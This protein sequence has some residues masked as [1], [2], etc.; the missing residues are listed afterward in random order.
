MLWSLQR[1]PTQRVA[2]DVP[3][4]SIQQLTLS[5]ACPTSVWTRWKPVCSLQWSAQL[6]HTHTHNICLSKPWC[7]DMQRRRA[8]SF[9]NTASLASTVRLR[10]Q[11]NRPTLHHEIQHSLQFQHQVLAERAKWLNRTTV[12][13]VLQGYITAERRLGKKQLDNRKILP[14]EFHPK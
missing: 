14:S 6:D 9:S 12:W 8:R 2:Y 10:N 7:L 5:R 4:H 3:P 11:R 1:R 13:R